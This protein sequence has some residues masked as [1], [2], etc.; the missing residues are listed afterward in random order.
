[1]TVLVH[2][3]QIGGNLVLITVDFKCRTPIYEQI[4]QNIKTLI[5]TGALQKGE[6]LPSVRALSCELGINPNTIQRAYSE[7]E[8]DGIILTVNGKGCFVSD[9][10]SQIMKSRTD[11]ALNEVSVK[12]TQA[13][14][15][16]ISLDEI[17]SL[18][19]KIYSPDER[20]V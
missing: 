16:G 1:V 14:L 15:C 17:N 7:L 8:H 6:Q 3:I 11:Q 9:D 20:K 5:F 4:K 18:A 2:L 13:K 12:I 10:T 19:H